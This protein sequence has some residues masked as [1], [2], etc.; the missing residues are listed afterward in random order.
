MRKDL[1]AMERKTKKLCDENPICIAFS[2]V[3]L[4][5]YTSVYLV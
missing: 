1:Q 2:I 5:T 4:T 3:C